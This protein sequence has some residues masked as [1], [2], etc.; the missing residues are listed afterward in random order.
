MRRQPKLAWLLTHEHV[1]GPYCWI[2]PVVYSLTQPVP[3]RGQR[4]LFDVPEDVYLE[5][6]QFCNKAYEAPATEVV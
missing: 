1:E 2:L 4:K 5:A 3:L 6:R